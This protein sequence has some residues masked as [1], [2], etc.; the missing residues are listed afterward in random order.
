MTAVPIAERFAAA[1]PFVPS[2]ADPDIRPTVTIK[3]GDLHNMATQAE[4]ALII[5]GTPFYVRGGSVVRPVV[6][7]LPSASGALVKAA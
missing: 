5:A 7:K 3:A 1:E 2:A 4:R 6:D